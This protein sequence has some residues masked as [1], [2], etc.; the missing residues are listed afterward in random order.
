MKDSFRSKFFTILTVTITVVLAGVAIFTAVR[1]YQLRQESVSPA[2]PESE[3]AAWD[4]KNYTFSLSAVGVVSVSNNSSRSE[5][6]Q[7]AKVYI[8][9]QLVATFD[10]PALPVGQ[11]A[12]LGT[13]N[14]PTDASFSWKVLGTL[15]CQNSGTITPTPIACKELQFTITTAEPTVTTTLTPTPIPT[16]T[17]T[18]TPT[19]K[20]IGGNSPTPTDKPL[21]GESVSPTPVLESTVTSTPTPTSQQIAQVSPDS[22]GQTLP[23]AG[24][25]TPTLFGLSLGFLMI[26]TALFLAL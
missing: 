22:R 2:S 18:P 4:C 5:P 7:Q 13:V 12:T 20:P 21:G 26:M 10:V 14:V 17:S 15:D 9:E 19:D 11:S 24:I 23:D 8:N 6:P 16:T 25:S 3:P 1:L